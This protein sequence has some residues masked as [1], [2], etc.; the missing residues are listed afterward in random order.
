MYTYIVHINRNIVCKCTNICR[1]AR[2]VKGVDLRS[3]AS[4]WARR[5]ESSSWQVSIS[6]YLSQFALRCRKK[7]VNRIGWRTGALNQTSS[8]EGTGRRL[9]KGRVEGRLSENP[10]RKD[11]PW[12]GWRDNSWRYIVLLC[13]QGTGQDR[14]GQQDTR[15]SVSA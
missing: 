12:R 10:F 4:P 5:F 6:W 1:L 2:V 13:T 8:T 9:L 11:M 7:D 14:T 3:T 15:G